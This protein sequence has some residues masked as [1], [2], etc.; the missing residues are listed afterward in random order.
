MG[1]K[2]NLEVASDLLSRRINPERV[3]VA[4]ALSEAIKL[5]KKRLGR[6]KKAIERLD[7]DADA[8]YD[9][10]LSALKDSGYS[11]SVHDAV[12]VALEGYIDGGLSLVRARSA[13]SDVPFILQVVQRHHKVQCEKQR[14]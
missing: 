3:Y 4:F 13:V 7:A 2:E 1:Y 8:L 5:E 12:V 9:L 10:V 14:A 11:T 6:A